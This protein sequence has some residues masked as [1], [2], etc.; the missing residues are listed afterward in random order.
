MP[1]LSQPPNH[2][3]SP[4][5]TKTLVS[6][7]RSRRCEELEPGMKPKC[8]P[9]AAAL[10]V[11]WVVGFPA[12]G[13]APAPR[14]ILSGGHRMHPCHLASGYV[15]T[16]SPGGR[17]AP[18]APSGALHT[19]AVTF[20]LSRALQES[21]PVPTCSESISSSQTVITLL[22]KSS[23]FLPTFSCRTS[24]ERFTPECLTQKRQTFISTSRGP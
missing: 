14:G 22:H 20:K 19:E 6:F 11:L 18:G 13:S 7:G 15:D 4:E 21:L 1:R 16:A 24:W 10:Q 17:P 23:E 12:R 8:L 3:S 9:Q 5:L 2:Q